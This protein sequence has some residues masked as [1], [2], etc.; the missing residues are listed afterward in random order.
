MHH[1]PVFGEN[2]LRLAI[3]NDNVKDIE[4]ARNGFS[5]IRYKYDGSFSPSR[6]RRMFADILGAIKQVKKR[7][8]SISRISLKEERKER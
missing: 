3:A 1:R 6:G 7:L 5:I 2:A 4:L 8:P